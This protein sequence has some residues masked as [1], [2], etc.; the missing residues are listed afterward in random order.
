MLMRS[1]R[2]GRNGAALA[3]TVG[4]MGLLALAA[5]AAPV[6]WSGNAGGAWVRLFVDGQKATGAIRAQLPEVYAELE[7]SGSG[8]GAAYTG[9][10]QGV[11]RQAG[12]GFPVTGDWRVRLGSDAEIEYTV[13]PKGRPA[14]TGRVPLVQAA[15]Y[16]L[17][18]CAWVRGSVTRTPKNGA[19]VAL[20]TNDPVAVGDTLE[21]AA[22]G[23]AVVVLGDRSVVM[24]QGA[25]RLVIPDVPDNR[26]GVQQTRVDSGKVWFAVR[27]V[28]DRKFEVET[29][30]AVAAVRGTEFLVEVGDGGELGVTT[31]EGEVVMQDRGRARAAVPVRAGMHC[32]LAAR[33]LRAKGPWKA[34]PR[35]DLA[36]VVRAWRPLLQQADTH[37]PLRREGKARFWQD[38]F[39]E[40]TPAGPRGPASP[41]G[42]GRRPG[43]RR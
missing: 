37:W 34:G 19:R 17:L 24:M 25:T 7:L 36:G 40:T 4:L 27:K 1:R 43:P 33:H 35:G 9:T 28:Q 38:S 39:G 31:A 8:A 30:E 23:G 12:A 41:R 5:R 6:Q 29:E 13:R 42:G 14:K 15:G 18:R 10:L 16:A 20:K 11:A 22:D 21:T 2:D 32:R 3:A 26:Q